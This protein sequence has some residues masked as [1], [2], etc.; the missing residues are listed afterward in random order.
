MTES[1]EL[2]FPQLAD[3]HLPDPVPSFP[4]A[5]GWWLL[6]AL[7]VILIAAAAWRVYRH[8]QRNRYRRLAAI[9]L[10]KLEPLL[11]DQHFAS[12]VN[13]LLRRVALQVSGS[14][15]A[16]LT[17]AEWYRYLCQQGGKTDP[18]DQAAFENWQAIAYGAEGELDRDALRHFA[19]QWLRYH[20]RSSADTRRT[21]KANRRLGNA[22]V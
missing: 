11:S 10:N 22:G 2:P 15:A 17:G 4:W 1:T 18:I 13:Q 3:I 7:G 6:L 9:E 14:N 21:A 20:H 19:S 8:L 12:A 5:P 16:A